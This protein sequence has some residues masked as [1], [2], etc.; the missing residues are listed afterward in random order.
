M[1]NFDGWTVLTSVAAS[2][3]MVRVERWLSSRDTKKK[4]MEALSDVHLNV[5][6]NYAEDHWKVN[7][8]W[9]DLQSNHIIPAYPDYVFY[10][11]VSDDWNEE[12]KNWIRQRIS[13]A[14][15]MKE[16]VVLKISIRDGNPFLFYTKFIPC[17][18]EEAYLFDERALEIAR[19][20]SLDTVV[21]RLNVK[22]KF[23]N[24][25]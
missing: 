10:P 23:R 14:R 12:M 20:R 13:E 4:R 22:N 25:T 3:I 1:S 2:L 17:T 11:F 18:P 7:P 21:D 19:E 15:T 5:Q 24:D 8:Y 9:I 16:W 6:R